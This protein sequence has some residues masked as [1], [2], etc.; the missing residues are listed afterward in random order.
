MAVVVLGK[1]DAEGSQH[2]LKRR[3]RSPAEIRGV[4]PPDVQLPEREPGQRTRPA[5]AREH[6]GDDQIG[7][8]A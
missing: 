4:A 3:R 8:G 6:P 1:H 7:Q 2:G 5:D